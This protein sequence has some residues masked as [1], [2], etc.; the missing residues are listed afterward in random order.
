MKKIPRDTIIK[1]GSS[2]NV[3]LEIQKYLY[4][5]NV[6]NR[7][8]I[9]Q[10]LMTISTIIEPS[11]APL[12]ELDA[13]AP[14]LERLG[15]DDGS[16]EGNFVTGIMQKAKSVMENVET[17]DPMAAIVGLLSS[18]LVTDM[19]KGLQNG[20]QDGTMNMSKLIGSMQGALANVMPPLQ[21]GTCTEEVR[22]EKDTSD[23]Q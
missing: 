12:A 3:Y 20:V 7:E 10:H 23:V 16:K 18:G 6:D 2:K 17:D 5:A 19:M 22:D 4:K 14:F 13:T 21:P 11:E 9:R 8:I 15:I 1:Y